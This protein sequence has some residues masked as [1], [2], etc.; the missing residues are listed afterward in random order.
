MGD[1]NVYGVHL[2]LYSPENKRENK[3]YQIN[4]YQDDKV[5]IDT[6]YAELNPGDT[7]EGE[8]IFGKAL[9]KKGSSVSFKTQAFDIK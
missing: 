4:L 7:L 9:V 2:Y 3:G 6:L 5:W 8:I 1:K